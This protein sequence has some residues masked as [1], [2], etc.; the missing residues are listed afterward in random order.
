MKRISS[1]LCSFRGEL[2]WFVPLFHKLELYPVYST[3]GKF[4]VKIRPK[5]NISLKE[6][7]WGEW[8]HERYFKNWLMSKIMRGE[9]MTDILNKFAISLKIEQV[10]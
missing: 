4:G 10:L 9:A 3:Q 1:C 8:Y 7:I 5:Y 2:K 6:A